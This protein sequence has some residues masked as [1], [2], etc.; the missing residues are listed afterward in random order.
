MAAGLENLNAFLNYDLDIS[1]RRS[2]QAWAILE[3]KNAAGEREEYISIVNLK[4][5][6][7]WTKIKLWWNDSLKKKSIG[8][9]LSSHIKEWSREV[10]NDHQQKVLFETQCA[11]TVRKIKFTHHPHWKLNVAIKYPNPDLPGNPVTELFQE[12]DFDR[13]TTQEQIHRHLEANTVKMTVQSRELEV[14][15]M[16]VFDSHIFKG[17]LNQE[18]SGNFLKPQDPSGD[19]TCTIELSNLNQ[20]KLM[21]FFT[22]AVKQDAYRKGLAVGNANG[23]RAGYRHGEFAGVGEIAIGMA[24]GYALGH[25]LRHH[26]HH[27]RYR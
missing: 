2:R 17:N 26:H 24:A 19:R 23:Y 4:T 6:S 7:V 18:R 21:T 22:E 13:L 15:L 8:N 9:F 20:A 12:I 5:A 3:R 11:K 27:R 25:T 16:A 14:P 10:E 1:A